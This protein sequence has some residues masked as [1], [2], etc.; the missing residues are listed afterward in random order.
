MQR[1]VVWSMNRPNDNDTKTDCFSYIVK[2]Y[3]FYIDNVGTLAKKVLS[4][5]WTIL[6]KQ[7]RR[8]KKKQVNIDLTIVFFNECSFPLVNYFLSYIH[9]LFIHEEINKIK[10]EKYCFVQKYNTWNYIN[11]SSLIE[12]NI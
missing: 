6:S 3:H 2:Q 7:S 8:K 4:K 12:V 5:P 10:C 11:Q 1:Q 9:H